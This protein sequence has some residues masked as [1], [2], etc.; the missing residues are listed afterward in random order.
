MQKHIIE[1]QKELRDDDIEKFVC[2]M[3]IIRSIK[4]PVSI[5]LI[6]PTKKKLLEVSSLFMGQ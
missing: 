4:P 2:A 6:M 5:E 3:L 1:V